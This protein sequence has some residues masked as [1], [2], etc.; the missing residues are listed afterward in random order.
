M[1]G[2][3]LAGFLVA[4]FLGAFCRYVKI[5]SPAPQALMGSLLVVTVTLGYMLMDHFLGSR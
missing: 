3:Y 4:F 2:R 5:P 1:I